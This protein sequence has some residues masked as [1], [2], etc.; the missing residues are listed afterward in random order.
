MRK[1]KNTTQ[2]LVLYLT[3]MFLIPILFYPLLP[4][5]LRYPPGTVDTA[6]QLEIDGMGYT[7]Q[8]FFMIVLGMSFSVAVLFINLRKINIYTKQLKYDG[9]SGEKVIDLLTKIKKTCFKTPYLLYALQILSPLIVMPLVFMLIKANSMAIIKICTTVVSFF[10]FGAIICLV[11]SQKI[12]KQILIDLHKDYPQEFKLINIK[13]TKRLFY[14]AMANNLFMQLIPLL[15]VALVFTSLIAYSNITTQNGDTA[16]AHYSIE[17]KER[18]NG[19]KCDSLD[20][21]KSKLYSMPLANSTHE[22]FIIGEDENLYT[23]NNMEFTE[24][25]K[26]YAIELSEEHS[27]RIYEYYCVDREA[28]SIKIDTPEMV[29]YAGIAYDTYAP[30]FVIT[31]LWFAIVLLIINIL[32]LY[33]IAISLAKD[34]SR[35][36]QNLEEIS[37]EETVEE[38]KDIAVTSNDEV[39]ELVSAFNKVQDLTK[40]NIEQIKSNQD[41]LIEKERLASLGQLIGG[42]AHNL[43][44]PIMSVS[45]ALQAI[46]NLTEE[47]DNSLGNPQVTEEDYREIAKEI[48][49][50]VGK[51]KTHIS[52]MSDVITAVRGQAVALSNQDEEDFTVG[53]LLK[54]IDILMMH[55]LKNALINLKA[56][57][58]IDENTK[59]K[60]N[61][62]SLVQVINNMISNSIQ[63]YAGQ[64][65]KDIEL[66]VYKRENELVIAIKD[67]ACGMPDFVKEKLLKEMITT[68]GKN[69]SGLGIYM[70]Y[71]NIKAH[72]GGNIKFE[73]EEGKGTTFYIYLPLDK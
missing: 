65:G 62:N 30:A 72:F 52:Y 59:L 6:F 37:N 46:L 33:Y 25:F 31:L 12:Y 71:S 49:E 21:I 67:Y 1:I 13:R 48:N 15:I 42:I 39:G 29:Y 27:G 28:T 55:E 35:I 66:S 32:V 41:V 7:Q 26:K 19:N 57:T 14:P 10:T 58:E 23:V 60:G 43:K 18:F 9:T 70:S 2:I 53:E 40:Q 47:Y 38:S 63:A 17:L 5:I 44:T 22:Y 8:Y 73:S 68:K 64:T 56:K 24:F 4:N 69:G 36:S 16:F 11:F 61:I 54:H 45:G 51:S 50:W 20:E 34:I 3:I